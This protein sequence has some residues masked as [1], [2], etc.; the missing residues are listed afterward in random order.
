MSPKLTAIAVA[1][2]VTAG[3]LAVARPAQAGSNGYIWQ[4]FFCKDNPGETQCKKR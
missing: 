1:F 3:A 2:A 4:P